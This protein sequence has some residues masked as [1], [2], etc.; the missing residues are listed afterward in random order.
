MRIRTPGTVSRPVTMTAQPR[1]RRGRR[2][3]APSQRVAGD[4][5]VWS[6]ITSRWE[7]IGRRSRASTRRDARQRATT[8]AADLRRCV[9]GC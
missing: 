8:R 6:C 2:F 7:R 9:A 4:Y 5:S 1:I 3:I